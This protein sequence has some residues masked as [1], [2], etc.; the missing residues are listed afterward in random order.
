[1]LAADVEDPRGTGMDG[2]A[3]PEVIMNPQV[4][5]LIEAIRAATPP[6]APRLWDLDPVAARAAANLFF[7][8]LNHGG[9]EMAEVRD[10]A[11][12]GR[13]GPI[14]A[15]LYVPRTARSLSP[16]LLFFHGGG[17]VIG[18]PATHDR[19]ARELAAG[20]DARVLS[21][22]YALAPEHPYPEGLDD[23]VDS[24]R[25]LGEHGRELGVDSGQ[26]VIG[27]DSAGAN[28]AAATILRLRDEGWA[29]TFR[30][31]LLI[32]GR[33]AR[34]ET[35]SIRAWGDRDLILSQRVMQWFEGHYVAATAR[36]DDDPYLTP[37]LADL[38]GFPRRS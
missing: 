16:G 7:A 30:G 23:C 8:A 18:S 29:R 1:M 13:R 24:A 26:L 28:L 10:V 33:F 34:G 15:H 37:L 5:A 36:P 9:P 35:P 6:D 22:D 14:P 11:I 21:I 27:G 25:W 19:L 3:T 20:S 32:Y 12:P 2:R 4:Q 17:F 31:A 38:G